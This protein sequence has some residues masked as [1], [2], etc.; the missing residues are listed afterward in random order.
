MRLLITF[1][2]C[3]EKK[4]KTSFLI[5]L[6]NR[7]HW[8]AKDVNTHYVVLWHQSLI[9]LIYNGMRY[10]HA[11]VITYCNKGR[12]KK[13]LTEKNSTMVWTNGYEH[14]FSDTKC[15]VSRIELLQRRNFNSVRGTVFCK[16]YVR[17]TEHCLQFSTTWGRL[18]I[19][20]QY[21]FM[22]WSTRAAVKGLWRRLCPYRGLRAMPCWW[23]PRTAKQ[24]S[25]AATAGVIVCAYVR[26]WPLY[27]GVCTCP[28][29]LN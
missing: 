18:E 15:G 20:R 19:S 17:R 11:P 13:I 10:F 26:Y 22:H 7:V 24:L 16:I 12:C 14:S 21:Q 28:S 3:Q 4:K 8:H 1:I 23:A 29:V 25:A 5:N 2:D 27:H 6:E 9:G